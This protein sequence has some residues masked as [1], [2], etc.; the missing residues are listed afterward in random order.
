MI[1]RLL[2]PSDNGQEPGAPVPLDV[3]LDA[4]ESERDV[5]IMRLRQLD[6]ILKTHGRLKHETL[7]ARVK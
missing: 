7:P 1:T 2:P 4:C 6:K 3:W 5:V